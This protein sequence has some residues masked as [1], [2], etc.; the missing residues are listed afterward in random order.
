MLRRYRDSKLYQQVTSVLREDEVD[1]AKVPDGVWSAFKTYME[2]LYAHAYFDFTEMINLAVQLLE[3]DPDGDDAARIVQQHIESDIR[4]VV[5]DEYQDVNPLQERLVRGL[6]GLGRTY[7]WLAT[8]IRR[9]ISGG[10]AK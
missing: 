6:T 2:L 3:G 4:Y 10:E 1:E 8:T 7:A 9:S 5:V